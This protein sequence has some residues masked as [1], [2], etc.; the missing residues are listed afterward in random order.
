[1]S[2][3]VVITIWRLLGSFENPNQVREGLITKALSG[4]YMG[5]RTHSVGIEPAATGWVFRFTS[6][7]A[8]VE[9][10]NSVEN[11][12]NKLPLD[13]GIAS[14]REPHEDDDVLLVRPGTTDPVAV[15][16]K[17]VDNLLAKGW[18]YPEDAQPK[19][20]KKKKEKV[21]KLQAPS[22]SHPKP[23]VPNDDDPVVVVNHFNEYILIKRKDLE[24]YLNAGWRTGWDYYRKVNGDFE[25]MKEQ[26]KFRLENIE[27]TVNLLLKA[28]KEK[29]KN[30]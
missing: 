15:K 30:E 4:E 9:F 6:H 16:R 1:M 25:D 7:E 13:T 20:E 8:S 27:K 29:N 3:P 23:F 11:H 18:V 19:Q 12:E 10:Q 28:A 24:V 17:R 14:P 21:K 5:T 22:V 26:Y 2:E